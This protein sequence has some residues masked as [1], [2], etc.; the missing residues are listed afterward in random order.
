MRRWAVIAAIAMGSASQ[1][2]AH[3]GLSWD[4]DACKLSV[5]PYLL[6]FTGFQPDKA[7]PKEFCED[8]P[9]VGKT[10]VVLDY[11]D[12]ALRSMPVEIR[13][14]KDEGGG[15][16]SSSSQTV[17]HKPA[18]LYPGGSVAFEYEFDRPGR[19]VGLVTAGPKGEYAA[20]FPF[21]VGPSFAGTA[22]MLVVGAHGVAAA[23]A[24]FIFLGNRSR[25]ARVPQACIDAR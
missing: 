20:K 25:R 10:V 13:I 6:H 15:D 3:G 19:Y 14:V 24:F 4:K 17:F 5:G 22:A 9:N 12:R 1:A 8:I 11:Q 2:A 23:V 16:A 21:S 18:Q 7:G